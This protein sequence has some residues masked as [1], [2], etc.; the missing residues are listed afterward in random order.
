MVGGSADGPPRPYPGG[1]RGLQERQQ[2]KENEPGSR[3]LQGRPGQTIRAELCP[4][5]KK[6]PKTCGFVYNVAWM[7]EEPML[8]YQHY[9][10]ENL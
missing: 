7:E 1:D 5:G 10:N 9:R 2:P 8:E 4:Q 3:S 6:K